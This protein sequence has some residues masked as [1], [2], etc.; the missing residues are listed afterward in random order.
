MIE[1]ATDL[2][3]LEPNAMQRHRAGGSIS[4]AVPEQLPAKLK[5]STVRSALRR[6]EAKDFVM[7]SVARRT[8]LLK[9]AARQRNMAARAVQRVVDRLCNGLVEEMRVGM[10]DTHLLDSARLP[11]LVGRPARAKQGRT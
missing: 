3:D 10:V 11:G 1:N 7:H 9:A 2:G 8:N 4:K 5:R 6:L